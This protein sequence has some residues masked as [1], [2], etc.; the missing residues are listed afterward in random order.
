[1]SYELSIDAWDG[2]WI[3]SASCVSDRVSHAK[4]TF[5][6]DRHNWFRGLA[7]CITDLCSII[8]VIATAHSSAWNN[9]A[10]GSTEVIAVKVFIFS[11]F[12]TFTIDCDQLTWATHWLNI[13][14]AVIGTVHIRSVIEWHI[15]L[16]AE[17]C[18]NTLD[19]VTSKA[20]TLAV[21]VATS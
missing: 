15:A 18:T 9:A 16:G 3:S 13:S 10:A 8:L 12:E 14:L 7:G 5:I 20:D 19:E 21:C 4:E 11:R 2:G 1:M 17:T 6:V